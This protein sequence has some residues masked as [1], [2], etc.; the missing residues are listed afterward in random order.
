V[1][2]PANPSSPPCEFFGRFNGSA[3]RYYQNQAEF[4]PKQPGTPQ[5]N[6][7]DQTL[8]GMNV[9]MTVLFCL[10]F[11]LAALLVTGI[12]VRSASD[13]SFGD[14]KIVGGGPALQPRNDYV[15]RIQVNAPGLPSFICGGTLI[16][17]DIVLTAAQCFR[18]GAN[19]VATIGASTVGGSPGS[20][21][22]GIEREI[23]QMVPHPDYKDSFDADI[24]ILKLSQETTGNGVIPVKYN[25]DATIPTTGQTAT[26]LGFGFESETAGA[27]ADEL[28]EASVTIADF[29]ECN[30]FYQSQL[31]ANNHIC[32]GGGSTP[33]NDHC[34]GDGG[35]LQDWLKF[36]VDHDSHSDTLAQVDLS[37]LEE[38]RKRLMY[39]LELLH[40]EL[41]VQGQ[42]PSVAT[43]R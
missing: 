17:S 43:Q 42:T 20:S 21:G 18:E 10:V 9:S 22:T 8:C 16:H 27:N 4:E 25:K 7:F 14:P 38:V 1:W 24:M 15:V 35:T 2:N 37:L 40:S 12:E 23:S 33:G 41:A 29:A 6:T 32:T 39:R 3:C 30:F 28:R 31:D 13:N 34:F 11:S 26:I 19:M 5:Q 36:S